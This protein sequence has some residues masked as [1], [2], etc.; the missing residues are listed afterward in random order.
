MVINEIKEC[1]YSKNAKK[2]LVRIM[3]E[4]PCSEVEVQTQASTNQT[5]RTWNMLV[6][7]QDCVVT[8]DDV[9]NVEGELVHYALYAGI[10]PMNVIDALKDP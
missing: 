5:L 8:P 6:R 1:Y 4:E 2:N 3:Y 9:V 10:E 7:L